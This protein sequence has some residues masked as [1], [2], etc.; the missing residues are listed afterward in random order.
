MSADYRL[1]K[2]DLN[3]LKSHRLNRLRS[4][5]PN[6]L[7]TSRLTLRANNQLLIH[8][9]EPWMVDDLLTEVDRLRWYTWLV[10]GVR[11][12]AICFADEEIYSTVTGRLLERG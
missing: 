5:F 12:V 9:S 1:T 6:C 3:L 7:T 2:S 8:C 11:Q 10:L 4:F